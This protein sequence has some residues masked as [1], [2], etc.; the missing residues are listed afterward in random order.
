[1]SDDLTIEEIDVFEQQCL[2]EVNLL[3]NDDIPALDAEA[4]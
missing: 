4:S 3:M 2:D 1:M